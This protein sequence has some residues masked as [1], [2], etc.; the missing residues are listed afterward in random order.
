MF[1]NASFQNNQVCHSN[2]QFARGFVDS[3]LSLLQFRFHPKDEASELNAEF[4]L[5]IIEFLGVFHANQTKFWNFLVDIHIELEEKLI[6][7]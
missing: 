2:L 1:L 7:N 3:S 6:S 4:A 5:Q